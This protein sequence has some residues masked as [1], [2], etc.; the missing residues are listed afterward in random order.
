MP[1]MVWTEETRWEVSAGEEAPRTRRAAAEV[2][3]ERPAIG[4]YSWFWVGS[5]ARMD[6][7]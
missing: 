4:R 6:S 7:T 3:V 2:K 5:E 1:E